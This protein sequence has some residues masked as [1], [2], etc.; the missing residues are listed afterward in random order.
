MVEQ[1]SVRTKKQNNKEDNMH[2]LMQNLLRVPGAVRT[3]ERVPLTV[4]VGMRGANSVYLGASK[5]ISDGGLFVATTD[6]RPVGDHFPVEFMLPN[7]AR[8]VNCVVE[9]MWI[10]RN[11]GTLRAGEMAGMGLKFLALDTKD[12]KRV[13]TFITKGAAR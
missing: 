3:F 7:D 5:N 1:K 11:D 12:Q 10:R 6:P 13:A 2:A 9:V 4:Q 8:P